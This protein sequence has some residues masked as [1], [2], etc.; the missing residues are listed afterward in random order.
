LKII[1]GISRI[2]S[3]LAIVLLILL[4]LLTVSDVFL[5]Y[6]FNSPILGSQEIA[7]LIMVCLVIGMAWCALRG[8]HIK[9]ELVMKRFPPRAQG[10][11]KIITLLGSLVMCVIITWRS[12]LTAIV[13]L[14]RSEV[15]STIFAAPTFPSYALFVL[16][17]GILCLAIATLLIQKIV[18][19]VKN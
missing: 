13:H 3:Y 16:G 4:M 9:V 8:E 5:R 11:V 12:S 15:A 10:I 18:E 1:A 2:L 14:E 7:K 17:W 6:A 19:A